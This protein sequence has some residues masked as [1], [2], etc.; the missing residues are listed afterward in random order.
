[1]R[2]YQVSLR[3]IM[4]ATTSAAGQAI[5]KQFRNTT[6]AMFSQFAECPFSTP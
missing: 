4:H 1:M 2:R 6:S 5:G 3:G